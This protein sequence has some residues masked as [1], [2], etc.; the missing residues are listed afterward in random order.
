MDSSVI[1][2]MVS[3]NSIQLESQPHNIGLNVSID[4]HGNSILARSVSQ[5]RQRTEHKPRFVEFVCSYTES[6]QKHFGVARKTST[7]YNI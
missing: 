7:S 1:L 3:E 5:G 4:S 2:E 6:Y